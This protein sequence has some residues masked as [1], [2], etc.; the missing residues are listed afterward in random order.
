MFEPICER[1]VTAAI[2]LAIGVALTSIVP[3]AS[4]AGITSC[5]SDADCLDPSRPQCVD[6]TC[7]PIDTTCQSDADCLLPERPFCDMSTSM[8][9][10]NLPTPT[11]TATAT[12]VPEGGA[13]TSP[14]ECASG[15]C[16]EGLCAAAASPAPAVSTAGYFAAASAL[17]LIAFLAIARRST[18]RL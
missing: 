14:A 17:L 3:A 4:L 6:G 12:Q 15:V 8:C 7:E 1:A 9:V 13:C 5:T 11:A 2:N 16:R 10:A 18:R